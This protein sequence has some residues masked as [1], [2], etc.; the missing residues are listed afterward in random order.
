VVSKF[1]ISN[2][3]VIKT[4]AYNTSL[5]NATTCPG[6]H[7]AYY[8]RQNKHVYF[9]CS[10]GGGVVEW[11]TV[12]DTF[13]HQHNVRGTVFGTPRDDRIFVTYGANSS[14][15]ILVPG[16]NGVKSTEER[17]LVVPS[18]PGDPVFFTDSSS[19]TP[20]RY[21]N[22]SAWFPTARNTNKN[23]IAAAGAD[24]VNATYA[25]RPTDCRYSNQAVVSTASVGSTPATGLQLAAV[26]GA[27]QT[28]Q[29]GA[30]APGINGSDPSQFDATLAGFRVARN[31]SSMSVETDLIPAGAVAPVRSLAST[32]NECSFASVSRAAKR[33][34]RYV[35]T[36]ADLPQPSLYVIDPTQTGAPGPVKGF[37]RTAASPKKVVWVPAA[38]A[39]LNG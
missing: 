29:C 20:S 24:V 30:C 15:T 9:E 33:G 6:T 39:N 17:T 5:A 36:I 3:T 2:D 7:S 35:V 1:D 25:T 14:S 34:G 12:N 10:G 21:S 19:I 23:N 37:V 22:Y 13:V 11:N 31:L 26:N 8:S 16:V 28:P 4:I 27:V 32:A 18:Q 38:V